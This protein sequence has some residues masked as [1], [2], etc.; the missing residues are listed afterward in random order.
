MAWTLGESVKKLLIDYQGVIKQSLIESK[1]GFM[2]MRGEF[3]KA[4]VPTENKR[5]YPRKI[6]EREIKKIQPAISQGKVFGHLD[7]P[8]SGKSSLHEV[9]HIITKLE[10]DQDGRILG[11]ARILKNRHGD[12]LKSILEAGGAVGVSSRGLG[13]TMMG[14][15]GNEIVGEDFE[16]FTHD[17]VLD[18]AVKTSYPKFTVESMEAKKEQAYVESKIQERKQSLKEDQAPHYKYAQDFNG[19]QI[20]IGQQNGKYVFQLKRKDNQ[21]TPKTD[22]QQEFSSHQEAVNAARSLIQNTQNHPKQNESEEETLDEAKELFDNGVVIYDN[23]GKTF[24]RYTIIIDRGGDA[25]WYNMSH[26]PLDPNGFNQFD[27]TTADSNKEGSHLGKKIKPSDYSKLPKDVIQAIQQRCKE[28]EEESQSMKDTVGENKLKRYKGISKMRENKKKLSETGEPDQDYNH[29]FYDAIANELKKEGYQVKHREFDK[30]QGIYLD[31]SKDGKKI[32]RFWGEDGSDD[33]IIIYPEKE[34]NKKFEVI[35]SDNDHEVYLGK[36][37]FYLNKVSKKVKESSEEN[38]ETMEEAKKP[39]QIKSQKDSGEIVQSL[40]D[41][42]SIWKNDQGYYWND[43]HTGEFSDQYFKTEDEAEKD[44]KEKGDVRESDLEEAKKQAGELASSAVMDQIAQLVTP[45]VLPEN[46]QMIVKE[47]EKE[48]LK[49]SESL[50]MKDQAI[51]K[52]KEE[53]KKAI[54]IARQLGLSLHLEKSLSEDKNAQAIRK[55]V[56]DLSKFKNHKDLDEAVSGAKKAIQSVIEEEKQFERRQKVL[57]A[58]YESKIKE[59]EKKNLKLESDL[60]QTIEEAKKYGYM[61]YIAHQTKNNP[62]QGKALEE[63]AQVTNKKQ[64]DAIIQK[65]NVVANQNDR[66]NSVRTRLKGLESSQLVENHLQTT[67]LKKVQSQQRIN[68]GVDAEM[69]DLFLGASLDEVKGLGIG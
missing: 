64:A 27:G 24:D 12:Q 65:Y 41:S 7:H 55:L 2:M 26:N 8:E 69:A 56:G 39:N 50:K 62:N 53:T 11:E 18:P 4:D 47:K 14:E 22:E 10:M 17:L 5:T 32:D 19:T 61:A 21:P 34:P 31:I 59:Y 66:Y 33:S 3:G 63:A 9:S 54:S 48:I 20:H 37:S 40:D 1:E 36:L 29:E 6:W 42:L 28:D 67:G 30:Y 58:Q 49:L 16:Y 60:K 46:I 25:D 45:F 68:E 38:E 44:A 13:S 43:K 51:I 52:L 35:V 57:K 15:D 23:G